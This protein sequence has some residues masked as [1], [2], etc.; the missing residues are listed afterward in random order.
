MDGG[1]AA[2]SVNYISPSAAYPGGTV[3]NGTLFWTFSEKKAAFNFSYQERVNKYNGG[4]SYTFVDGNAGTGLNYNTS[5][6]ADYPV[7]QVFN[8]KLYSGWQENGAVGQNHLDVYGG[9]S[10]WTQ[11][12]PALGF[13][14]NTASDAQSFNTALFGGRLYAAWGEQ[15]TAKYQ[16]RVADYNSNDAAPAFTFV[17]GNIVTGLNFDTAQDASYNAGFLTVPAL[18][19]LNN[20]LYVLWIEQNA[21]GKHQI[22]VSVGR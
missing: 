6:D 14:Y 2:S 4:S 10:T 20:G 5:N 8:N 21:V 18:V 15:D 11:V 9:G 17:D 1:V 19:T 22:R 16:L 13:N 7:L 12:S 3:F